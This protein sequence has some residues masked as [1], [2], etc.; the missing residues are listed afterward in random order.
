ML[1]RIHSFTKHGMLFV[2]VL[3][4]SP[5]SKSWPV[6]RNCFMGKTVSQINFNLIIVRKRE[7]IPRERN[8]GGHENGRNISTVRT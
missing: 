8:E 5:K 4:K 3:I 2:V 7:T 6:N 1:C